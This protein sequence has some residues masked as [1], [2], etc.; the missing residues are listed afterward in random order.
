MHDF[1]TPALLFLLIVGGYLTFTLFAIGGK[2]VF[3]E[4]YIEKDEDKK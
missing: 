2:K 3:F 1:H 4:P